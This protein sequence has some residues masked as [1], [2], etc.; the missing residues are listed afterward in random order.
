MAGQW[1]RETLT[2]EFP[3]QQVYILFCSEVCIPAQ[4][5]H[6]RV[7]GEG[8]LAFWIPFLTRIPFCSE[9][10]IP[11]QLDHGRVVGDGGP[12]FW[13]PFLT[14]IYP[15]LCRSLHTGSVRSRAS[16]GGGRARLLDWKFQVI[17]HPH[18][19]NMYR[20]WFVIFFLTVVILVIQ[21][22]PSKTENCT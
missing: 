16:G 19:T 12:A 10:C 21:N 14:R 2:S 6:G 17:P 15:I 20:N 11:A 4:L 22:M 8:G 1:G 18:L 9:D 7:V 5:D 3:F 13:I